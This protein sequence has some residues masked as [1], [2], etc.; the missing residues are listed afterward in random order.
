MTPTPDRRRDEPAPAWGD[1]PPAWVRSEAF[2]EDLD[3]L[4]PCL[5]GLGAADTI[6]AAPA[7]VGGQGVSRWFWRSVVARSGSLPAPGWSSPWS[8]PAP[9]R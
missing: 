1:E 3:G 2:A 7:R 6:P 4:I 8:G 9:A 5:V